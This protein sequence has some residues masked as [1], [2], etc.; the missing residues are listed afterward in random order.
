MARQKRAAGFAG[1]SPDALV[2]SGDATKKSWTK[3]YIRAPELPYELRHAAH[4]AREDGVMPRTCK[5]CSSQKRE[6]IDRALALGEPLRN[7]GKRVSISPA[8]LFRH[9]RLH[10]GEAVAK[11][12]EERKAEDKLT[13]EMVLN[14]LRL[15]GFYDPG[16]FFNAQGALKDINEMPP[17]VRAVI[18][19]FDFVNLYEGDGEQKHCFGQLRKIRTS[20][21]IAALK[22]LGQHFGLFPSNPPPMQQ[23]NILMNI[24]LRSEEDLRYFL[25]HGE[26]PPDSEADPGRSGPAGAIIRRGGPQT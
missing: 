7:I 21:Q 16:E 26:W 8:A 3:D 1:Q 15:H 14:R 9:K 18:K 17:E 13:G 2:G 25:A 11:V 23:N 22:A 4:G 10:I 12:V 24:Y 6:E 19:G 5:A 20:D